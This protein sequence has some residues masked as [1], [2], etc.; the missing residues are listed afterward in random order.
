MH[1]IGIIEIQAEE[2]Q[3]S[4]VRKMGTI[5]EEKPFELS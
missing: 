1:N 5:E 3:E 4:P 2:E